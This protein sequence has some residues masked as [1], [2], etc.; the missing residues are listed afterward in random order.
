LQDYG[1]APTTTVERDFSQVGEL[2][3]GTTV[4]L[5]VLVS[6]LESDVDIGA[7][8]DEEAFPV[9]DEVP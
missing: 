4:Y 6:G 2:A 3:P 7:V 5:D 9:L 1:T 8:I